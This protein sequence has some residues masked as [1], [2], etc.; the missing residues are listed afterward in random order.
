MYGQGNGVPQVLGVATTG[1]VL[2]LTGV[3]NSVEIATAA[4]AG[5]AVWAIVYLAYSKLGPH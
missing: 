5:L 4:A 3:S 2:P 1:A